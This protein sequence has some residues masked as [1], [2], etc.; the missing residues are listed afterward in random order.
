MIDLFH[1]IGKKDREDGIF[2]RYVW[3]DLLFI[4]AYFEDW[5]YVLFFSTRSCCWLSSLA[6]FLRNQDT[7][8]DTVDTDIILTFTDIRSMDTDTV[9]GIMDTVREYNAWDNIEKCFQRQWIFCKTFSLV[10]FL[11]S[12]VIS[13]M[14][15][16][17]IIKCAEKFYKFLIYY[18]F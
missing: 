13:Y 12:D 6:S 3:S 10:L 4:Y 8:V 2:S 7:S 14:K 11:L 16:Y 17:I 5:V 15:F 18:K 1:I 9:T